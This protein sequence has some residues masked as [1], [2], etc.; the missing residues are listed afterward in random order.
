MQ[1][2]AD[3]QLARGGKICA[4][5]ELRSMVGGYMKRADW[6]QVR[7]LAKVS[8]RAAPVCRFVAGPYR[9]SE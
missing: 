8:S 2:P 3:S 9:A 6:S 4:A 7:N 1:N 5:A